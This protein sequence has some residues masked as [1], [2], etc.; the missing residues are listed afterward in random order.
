MSKKTVVQET[1]I[2][3]HHAAIDYLT[4]TCWESETWRHWNHYAE[5]HKPIKK[6][7]SK[8]PMYV[9]NLFYFHSGSAFIGQGEQKGQ[10]HYVIK[11]SGNLADEWRAEAFAQ[12]LA[13]QVECTRLDLQVTIPEPPGWSQIA[14]MNRVHKSGKVPGWA[15]SK[16][17][18]GGKLETV[19]IG[20]WHSDRLSTVYV[21]LTAGNERLLRLETRYKKDR[22]NALLPQLA[23]GELPD[24]FLAHELQNVIKDSKLRIAFEP[25]LTI[26]SPMAAKVKLKQKED[27]T[28]EWLVE[29][30]LPTFARIVL[31]HDHD[32][33]VYA[34]FAEVMQK[35]HR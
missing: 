17:R 28:A 4:L 27:K 24:N 23:K 29:K 33:T 31:D 26:G 35:V 1:Y 34:A 9:G 20:S 14:L 3:L 6:L 25:S 19:Y 8:I 12:R 32:G 22:A 10:P 30:V 16:D 13:Y 2:D 7:D 15:A 11:I 21:K 18:N 5:I